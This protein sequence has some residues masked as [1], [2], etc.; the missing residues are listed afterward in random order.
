[1]PRVGEHVEQAGVTVQAATVLRW[2]GPGAVQAV[3]AGGRRPP[4]DAD[5]VLPA[6]T[7]V[8]VV[9]EDGAG[10]DDRRES[11]REATSSS[12]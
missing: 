6:V 4:D 11:G 12:D 8:V 10:L 5:V 7:E 9:P 3:G 2:A 1:M